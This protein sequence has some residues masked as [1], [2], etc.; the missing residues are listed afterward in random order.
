M[1]TLQDRIETLMW[2]NR[3]STD[4]FTYTL[5][6]PELYPFQW[7][8]DSCF[9][10]IILSHFDVSTAKNELRAAFSR[11]LSDGILP[12]II[13]WG[14]DTAATNW[15]REMRGDIIN[16]AWGVIG[17]SA[18]TQPPIMAY[19]VWRIFENDGDE[20][21]LR[22]MYP[23]LEAHYRGILKDRVLD[24]RALAFIVNPD[25][26]GE[27]NSPRFD[28]QQGLPA[29]HSADQSLDRRLDRIREHAVCQ[30]QARDCMSKYFAVADLPFNV[31]LF[32]SLGYMSKIASL[33][34]LE[35]DASYFATT[36]DNVQNAI[37]QTLCI[38]GVCRAYDLNSSQSI[39]TITWAIF[40]PLYGGLLSEDEAKR[41]VDDWLLS[42]QRFWSEF[43]IPSTS[44][45][46]SSFDPVGG[47]WRGPV[48]MAPNWFVYKG[49]KRYGFDDVAET[50]KQKTVDLIELSGFREQYNPL[51]GEGIGAKNFTW[52]G[53]VL[54][55]E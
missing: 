53:L 55:M 41:L 30:F 23:I 35:D 5:P 17:T 6:S 40:M 50:I 43:P 46:E 8:W 9:H 24:D 39:E 20:A 45:E 1:H 18:I 34:K 2:E 42:D 21:F 32:E 16:K 37:K 25:E 49:L 33:L 29:M 51:T 13:Y 28:I 52:G 19:A 31:I 3:R 10:A 47:F 38:E 14:S 54:D 36:A 26:S 4:G 12:H 22:E 27:D 44:M 15:G 11:P 48:W 7:L